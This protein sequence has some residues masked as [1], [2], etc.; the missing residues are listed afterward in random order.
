MGHSQKRLFDPALS[1]LPA[2]PDNQCLSIQTDHRL[3]FQ[4]SRFVSPLHTCI[5]MY[6][7]WNV[8]FFFQRILKIH[9][10]HCVCV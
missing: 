10:P 1:P 8:Y 7:C 3:L 5:Q 9:L 6:S 4:Q 2:V